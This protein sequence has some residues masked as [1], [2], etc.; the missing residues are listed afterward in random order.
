MPS[1]RNGGTSGGQEALNKDHKDNKVDEDESSASEEDSFSYDEGES[2]RI[3]SKCLDDM[4]YLEHQFSELK[5]LL[6]KERMDDVEQ[7]INLLSKDS[8][9]EY[10]NPLR[11]L[12]ELRDKRL[13]ISELVYDYKQ[14]SIYNKYEQ[15]QNSAILDY[16]ESA[17]LCKMKFISEIEDRIQRLEEEELLSEMASQSSQ[18]K[19]KSRPSSEFILLEKRK[20]PVAV[21]GPYI[22]YML[23]DIDIMEDVNDIKRGIAM[24]EVKKRRVDVLNHQTR[25]K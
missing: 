1:T 18:R 6:Y 13:Q 19:R 7:K 9:P 14:R 12:T 17:D 2:E 11:E 21:T 24:S 8:A 25:Q 16:H 3:K 4:V 20:K 5:E 22:V 15:E 10:V 23:R